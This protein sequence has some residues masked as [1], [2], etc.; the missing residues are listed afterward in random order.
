M[1]HEN[2]NEPET[3]RWGDEL[4]AVAAAPIHHKV[5]FEN[6]HVRVLDT[7]IPPGDTTPVHSHRWAS[8]V[9]TLRTGDF[10][11]VSAV[12]RSVIDTRVT[13]ITIELDTPKHIPPLTPHSVRNVGDSEL[14]A[15]VVEVKD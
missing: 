2:G 1:Q 4:D 7:R 6:R 12:D 13:P 10:V 14:R 3:P 9:Y 11:R 5:I 8:V 15:I